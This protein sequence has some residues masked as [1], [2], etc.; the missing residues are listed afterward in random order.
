ML[1][2]TLVD[3][4]SQCNLADIIIAINTEYLIIYHVISILLGILCILYT[5][6]IFDL[7]SNAQP[8]INIDYTLWDGLG[9]KVTFSQSHNG[10]H[11][12]QCSMISILINKIN[13]SSET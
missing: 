9:F 13:I 8:S 12:S 3:L 10:G 11:D 1:Y 4:Y 6:E 7:N 5:Q 2:Y